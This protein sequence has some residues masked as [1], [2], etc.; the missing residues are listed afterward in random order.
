VDEVMSADSA[1]DGPT[2]AS[3]LETWRRWYHLPALALVALYMFWVRVQPYDNF[4]TDNGV[5]FSGNDPY[6]HYRATMYTVRNW[7]ET[8]S[9]DPWTQFPYGTSVGQFGTLFDVVTATVALIVGLGDPSAKQVGTVAVLMPAV[10]G[11]LCVIPVYYL[12]HRLTEDRLS[13]VFGS[14][15]FGILPTSIWLSRST[16]GTFDH[17]VAETLLMSL[18]VLAMVVAVGVVQRQKPVYEQ[19]LDRDWDGLREPFKWSALAGVAYALYVQVW[20]PGA[21]IAGIFGIFFVLALSIE[22]VRE[23]SPEHL[24]F[25]GVSGMGVGALL[26]IPLVQTLELDTA[27]ISLLQV[28]MPL[29][30]AV[31]CLFMAWLARQWNASDASPWG[32]PLTVG[33]LL[34]VI[35]GVIVVALPDVWDLIWG[36]MQRILFLGQSDTVLTISEAQSMEIG[37]LGNEFYETYGYGFTFLTAFFA[38]LWLLIRTYV[39][40]QRW[41]EYLLVVVWTGFLTLM[42]VTQIRFHAYL[43]VPV[44]VLNG[45][46]F[47]MVVQLVDFPSFDRPKEAGTLL[48][49]SLLVFLFPVADER[50]GL[51]SS[52]S[53]GLRGFLDSAG[54]LGIVSFQIWVVVLAFFLAG[55][56][57]VVVFFVTEQGIVESEDFSGLR[58]Y[59][60]L[61]ILAIAM[62]VVVP[63]ASPAAAYTAPGI[64]GSSGPGSAVIWEDSNDWLQGSTPAPGDY[65]GAGNA[66]ELQY[67]GTYEQTSDFAYPEGGYGV[68]SWWDY[69]HW[70]TVQGERIPNANPFQQSVGIT[71][72]YLLSQNETRAELL[73]EAIPTTESPGR[74]R[75]KTAAELR[76]IIEEDR[77]AQEA[78][79]QTRYIMID[80]QM[81]G[82]KFGAITQWTQTGR[83]TRYF[84]P[85]ETTINNQTVT[86]NGPNENYDRTMLSRLYF[87][88]ARGLEHYRLVHENDRSSGVLSVARSTGRGQGTQQWQTI[89]RNRG[90]SSVVRQFQRSGIPVRTPRDI[91]RLPGFATFDER[92]AAAVK[93]FERV[94]GATLEGE[95]AP[96]A[97]VIASVELRTNTNR[98]FQYVQR[99]QADSDG[100]F[101][102]TVPY[103]TEENLGPDQGYTNASVLATGEYTVQSIANRTVESG[104]ATVPE[105]AVVAGESVSVQLSP[106]EETSGETTDPGNNASA[107][108]S[109]AVGTD[110]PAGTL[111]SSD[112]QGQ[113]QMTQRAITPEAK[114]PPTETT[115]KARPSPSAE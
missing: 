63:I 112:G 44:A 24:A 97:S 39:G 60:V 94:E 12:C 114:T 43:V 2:A 102:V 76:Q 109:P 87:G 35:L 5:N 92:G 31:G 82:G 79:E 74:L 111:P 42:A 58:S 30:V 8:L 18:T 45:W 68:L 67:Y 95:A 20:P 103:P 54:L 37:N 46:L 41:A 62:V 36:N 93:T 100:N 19:V 113:P 105:A 22:T 15:V 98:S 81:A 40:D 38:A 101:A 106:P 110:D 75:G 28:L 59:H 23:N 66:S 53:D 65:G 78:N 9:M 34:L 10:L 32:Y 48:S 89:I 27:T 73:L 29:T 64:A 91:N 99:E 90:V 115:P 50:H 107:V 85:T 72:E 1:E 52:M 61:V 56:A 57:A 70:I 108:V 6:Y 71:A 88:D 104:S 47:A 84:G 86:V 96:N 7:P 14:F 77:S 83:E 55:V 26:L 51:S 16:A 49:V 21:V 25:A 13:A 11:T 33:T 69:G 3:V 4:V 80:D 17:H